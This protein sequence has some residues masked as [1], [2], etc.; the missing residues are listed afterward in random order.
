MEILCFNSSPRSDGISRTEL[1][2][3]HLV[4]GMRE[5]GAHVSIVNLREKSIKS[6]LGCFMC[7]T[8]SPGQC[9]QKDDMSGD[10]LP[11]LP[12]ADLVVYATPLYNHTMN[13]IMSNFRERMLPLSHPFIEKQKGKMAFRLRHP[14]P[15]AVWL[16][17]CGHPDAAEFEALS[18]FLHH[19]H[20]PQTPI[21]AEIY[22][23]SAEALK[24][25]VFQELLADI[26]DATVQAGRELVEALSISPETLNRVMQ[27]LSDPESLIAI[28][29]LT[30][31]TCIAE[32]VTIEEF[33]KAGMKPRP[34][35]LETFMALS[36]YGLNPEANNGKR[37]VLQFTFTGD[38]E[39]ACHFTIEGGTIT[40]LP[41]HA[42]SYDVAI[43][44][45]FEVWMDIMTGKAEGQEMFLQ[46]RYRVEGDLALMIRL[47][48]RKN[49]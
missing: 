2:L 16:S 9:T 21:I 11:R 8:K 6:C 43:E 31:R 23:T 12:K 33:F 41:G 40:A 34:D 49:S 39:A 29:N 10:L 7:W 27:P 25:P 5:A 18:T 19:T 32:E 3:T 46:G 13:A 44:T 15:P 1:M 22:R 35:S 28:G 42:K 48:Q 38:L 4:Q 20:H 17:V 47:F 26:L 36:V 30:W 24:H 45:P 37:V 14:L